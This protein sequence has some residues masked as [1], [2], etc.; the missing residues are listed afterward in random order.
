MSEIQL[1]DRLKDQTFVMR[2]V[3]SDSDLH[4]KNYDP[5]AG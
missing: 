5:Q 2:D 4:G 1:S 3:D